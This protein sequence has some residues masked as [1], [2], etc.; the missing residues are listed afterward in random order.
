MIKLGIIVMLGLLVLVM[1]CVPA[2]KMCT[3]DKECVPAAC[4]HADDAVNKENAPNCAGMLCTT[5]CAPNTIDCQQ[6]EIKCVKG[7]CEAVPN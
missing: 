7:S 1:G 6:G 5:E 3:E 4:C 2:E